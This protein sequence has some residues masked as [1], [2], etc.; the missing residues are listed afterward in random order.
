[1]F[2]SLALKMHETYVM[3]TEFC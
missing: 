1:M 3:D 2:S